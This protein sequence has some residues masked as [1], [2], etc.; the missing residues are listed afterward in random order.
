DALGGLLRAVN[1][2]ELDA[3]TADR[4][5]AE[6]S[7]LRHRLPAELLGGEDP[8][9][10]TDPALLK[11]ALVDIKELLINRLLTSPRQT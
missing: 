11:D 4:L 5:A 7:T 1:A 8:F 3:S 10:P 2:L 9:D 6:L